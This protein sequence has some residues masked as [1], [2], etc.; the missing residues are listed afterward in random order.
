MKWALWHFVPSSFFVDMARRGTLHIVRPFLSPFLPHRFFSQETELN[1]VP[2]V[3]DT[4][5]LCISSWSDY[6]YLLLSLLKVT[7]FWT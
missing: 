3:W 6:L 1:G 7:Q 5:S 2:F 4:P